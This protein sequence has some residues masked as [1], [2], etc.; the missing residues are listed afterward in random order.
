MPVKTYELGAAA[1]WGPCP[2]ICLGDING[3][4]VVNVPD[5]LQLLANWGPCF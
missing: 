4:G 3:D 2:P 5:L 1:Q